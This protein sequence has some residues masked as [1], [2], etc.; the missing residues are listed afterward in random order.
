MTIFLR[1][2]NTI[3][4]FLFIRSDRV[5]AVNVFSGQDVSICFSKTQACFA[6]TA[7]CF[8]RTLESE[9]ETRENPHLSVCTDL[10]LTL[11]AFEKLSV[12]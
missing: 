6:N 9:T 10:N 2:I 1:K 12:Q 11:Y 3:V 7:S 5:M 4:E 8:L